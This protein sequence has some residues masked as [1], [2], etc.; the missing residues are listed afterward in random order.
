[1]GTEAVRRW[2][3]LV[4]PA[5]AGAGLVAGSWAPPASAGTAEV[6]DGIV[7]VEAADGPS[8]SVEV[9]R[10]L[11]D[12]GG[13][14]NVVVTT[15]EKFADVLAGGPLAGAFGAPILMTKGDANVSDSLP[16]EVAAEMARVATG[17]TTATILGGTAA[18]STRVEQEIA[19]VPGVASVR[20][21]FGADRTSTAVAVARDL[22]AE[23]GAPEVLIARATGGP[24]PFADALAGG[25]YGAGPPQAPI[26]LTDTDHLSEAARRFVAEE[27]G[28]AY[29]IL[30][31]P[32]AVGPA[33][34]AEVRA[35]APDTD[36]V[37]G[38][39]RYQTALE[40]ARSPRLWGLA[41]PCDETYALADGNSFLAAT[42]ASSYQTP[43]L[44][45]NGSDA[46]ASLDYLS[47]TTDPGCKPV[48]LVVS[49]G[50]VDTARLV[51][52]AATAL[53][54]GPAAPAGTLAAVPGR[55]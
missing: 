53:R 36:R 1:M 31:G 30:G 14:D 45:T 33:V 52:Q 29:S 20:R 7:V 6:R 41:Q 51:D 15:S 21:L 47:K 9:S 49:G 8:L 48:V 55:R 46:S 19:A 54:R 2:G 23:V 27:P 50:G 39:D 42:L 16:P 11:F 24:V 10:S 43:L 3:R 26:L 5:V 18:V 37:F 40:I 4:A 12:D 22:L 13:A 25:A 28:L 17:S 32:A 38:A 34:E 44:L 35:L